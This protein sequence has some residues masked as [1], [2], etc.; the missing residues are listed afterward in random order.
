MRLQNITSKS[1]SVKS[2]QESPF[3]QAL[4]GDVRWAWIWLILRVYVGWQWLEAGFGKL[5]NPVWTGSKAGVALTG[6]INGALAKT[7]GDHP[8]LAKYRFAENGILE[9]HGS[10]G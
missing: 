7:A 9:L 2:I 5:Q 1:T 4:F 8:V 3:S 6:F 10:L